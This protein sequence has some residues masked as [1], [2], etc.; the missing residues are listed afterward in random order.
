[1]NINS[2]YILFTIFRTGYNR[3]R[4]PLK[5][6]QILAKLCK[7]AKIDPPT[8]LNGT[9]RIDR[10]LFR[11]ETLDENKE[12]YRTKGKKHFEVH[13]ILISTSNSSFLICRSRRTYGISSSPPLARNSKNR[14]RSV[15][16]TYR[17]KT[18]I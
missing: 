15:T 11:I 9:V 16:R 4:D 7:D 2:I 6:S 10:K 8:Y 5:P 17:D 18:T 14:M 12:W 1:M 3:W 13:F